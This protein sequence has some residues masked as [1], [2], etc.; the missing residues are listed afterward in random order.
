MQAIMLAGSLYILRKGL[1]I[2]DSVGIKGNR[3]KLQIIKMGNLLIGTHNSATGEKGK[4]ILS[5]LVTPFSKTQSK[6]I[7][8]QYNAGCTMFDIRFKQ[9]KDKVVICKHGLWSSKRTLESILN[10]I[11]NYGNCL[12][13]LTYEGKSNTLLQHQ[14]LIGYYEYIKK[15]YPNIT[16]QYLAIKY[17]K[18]S[19]GI[20]CRYDILKVDL[21]IKTIQGFLPLDGRSW[22]TY[23]PIPW[24]WKKIYNDTPT[25]NNEYYTYVDF[26]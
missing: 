3:I 25:F 22:H 15:K 21:P 8:E 12:V 23:L 10:Q 1:I 16:W 17:G 14:S 13:S 7:E 20:K 2:L 19:Q 18:N 4:G 9:D 26:L 24:L 5:W 6:T 11:N